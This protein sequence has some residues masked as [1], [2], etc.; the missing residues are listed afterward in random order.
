MI[1]KLLSFLA[2]I[3]VTWFILDRYYYSPKNQIKRL[4]DKVHKL[5]E[6]INKLDSDYIPDCINDSPKDKRNKKIY[7]TN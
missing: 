2:I 7:K 1:L 3:L 4:W 6:L 5:S